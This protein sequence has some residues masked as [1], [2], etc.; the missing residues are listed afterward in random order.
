MGQDQQGSPRAGGSTVARV[1]SAAGGDFVTTGGPAVG[2]SALRRE[3][4]RAI[5]RGAGI[6]ARCKNRGGAWT[7]CECGCFLRRGYRFTE[8]PVA[9]GPFA[10]AGAQPVAGD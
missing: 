9:A 4:R 1:V 7:L 5:R 10:V 2:R 6:I 8:H 3:S